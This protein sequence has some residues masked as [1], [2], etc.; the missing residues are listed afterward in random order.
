MPG[1]NIQSLFHVLPQHT[2]AL[3]CAK[4]LGLPQNGFLRGNQTY[5]TLWDTQP[6]YAIVIDGVVV[7]GVDLSI[8]P[9][10]ATG[11]LDYS[12]GRDHW[13]RGLVSEAARSVVRWGFRTFD[14]AKVWAT[15]DLRNRRSWRVIEK[16]GM[17][18]EGVLRSH[19]ERRGERIDSVYYGILREEWEARTDV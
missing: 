17:A 11:R 15:A 16:L 1:Y 3:T 12:I 6:L 9:Q 10:N 18:R 13:G 14:L 8:S 4:A 2:V 5:L 7:G 19:H